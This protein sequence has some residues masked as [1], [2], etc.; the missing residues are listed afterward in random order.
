MSEDLRLYAGT[1]EGLYVLRPTAAG[2]VEESRALENGIIDSMWGCQEH[3]ERVYV[4]VAHDGVY[5][6]DDAGAHWVKALDGDVRAV[7]V[8]PKHEEV[9]YAGMEPTHL[10]R[11]EDT[12]KTWHEVMGLMAMPQDVQDNWWS[13]VSGVGHVRNI[14]I[15]E[16]DSNLMLLSLEHGGIV[17][18]FDRGETWEDVSKGIDYLDIHL[19]GALPH[20]FNKYYV[21]SARG[22]FTATDPAEGWVRAE[23]GFTRDYF[24]DFLFLPPAVGGGTPTMLMA[25]A[26]HS[27]GYWDRP[28]GI[29]SARAAIFRSDDCAESWHRV[30]EGLPETIHAMISTLA[31]HPSDPNTA[32]AGM[33]EVSRGHAHG[34][35]GRGWISMTQDRGESW[36]DIGVDLPA[37]RVLWATPV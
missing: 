1:H 31:N 16:D 30:V 23:N 29:R 2:W 11:S 18:T 20:S 33:G 7:A 3:P 25:T 26:D 15:H 8:D 27:P 28:D 19:V 6:T 37:D 24:H 17:R 12:G 32:Y 35:A 4:G 36:Q 13:P 21:S 9:V 10:F 5:R 34:E 14:F 22:F